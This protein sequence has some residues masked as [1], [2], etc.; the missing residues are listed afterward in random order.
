MSRDSSRREFLT[1]RSAV[2]AL[3]DAHGELAEPLP[4]PGGTSHNWLTQISREAMACEFEVLLDA[5][6]HPD[7]PEAAVE[8]LDLVEAL[9]AQLTVYRETSEVSRLNQ[10]AF[11]EL[12]VVEQRLFELLTQAKELWKATNGALDITS[13]ALTKVWG[14]Y[15]RQGN[16]PSEVEVAAALAKVGSQHLVLDASRHT[17][18]FLV[19]GLEINLGAIGKGHTLDRCAELL[20]SRGIHDFLIHG[21]NSSVLA[22]GKRKAESGMRN[23]ECGQGTEVEPA[24][25]LKS[26][27]SNLKSSSP[28][29]QPP[30]PSPETP[31]SIGLRHPLRPDQR[32]AE[33][34]LSNQALGTSGSGSQFFHHGAKRYGH[35]LDPRTGWPA[36][37]VL[38]ATVIAPTAAEADALST[39][40]YV[41]GLAGTKKYCEQH[42]EITALLVT[43]K[44]AGVELHP[45]NLPDEKWH[46]V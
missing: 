24:D 36:E 44:G 5:K 23:P 37:Q 41:L 46:T 29:P 9:E 45:V 33:F 39:A 10:R 21:G 12:V 38:S 26:Q 15:R 19:P 2:R 22:R 42:P 7:G 27:I 8:A 32:L 25:S 17:A 13:G 20:S 14:F 11:A 6:Q 3:S 28:S 40:F 34:T 30:V 16:M 4:T 43:Q 1:G 31:W 18:Q 35:I